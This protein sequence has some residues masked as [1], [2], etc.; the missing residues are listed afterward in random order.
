MAVGSRRRDAVALIGVLVLVGGLVWIVEKIRTSVNPVNSAT[1]YGAYLAVATLVV[2]L[3]AYLLP[4]WWKG[5]R[6]I[7]VSTAVQLTAA[8]DQL[9]QRILN[10]WRQEAKERLIST[11][12][13]VRVRWQWGPAQVTPSLMDVSTAPVAGTGPDSLPKPNPGGSC[14]NSPGVLLEAGVVTRLH[15]ELYRTLSHGR[16]VLLGEPG[17]GKTGAMI[18]LLLAA[19]EYRRSVDKAQRGQVPVPVLLTLGS[20]DP[21][22]QMLH[23]WAAATMYRDHPYLRALDYGPNAAEEL[24]RAGQVALFLDGLDEMAPSARGKALTRIEQE[25]AGLRIVLSSRPEEYVQAISTERI[26]NTAVI[27]VQPVDPQEAR[28]YLLRDQVGFQRDRWVQLGDYLTDHPGSVAAHALNTPLTLSLIRATYQNHDPTSLTDPAKFV[29]AAALRE[30]L[31]DRILVVVYPEECQRAHASRWLAWI[32]SQLG[33]E[34]D[35]AWWRISSWVP[36]WQLRLV[37]TI[38]GM[39]VGGLTYGFVAASV[40]GLD[41]GLVIGLVG[42]LGGALVGGLA[43]G[44][45]FGRIIGLVLGLGGGLVVGLGSSLGGALGGALVGGLVGGLASETESEPRTIFPRW[46]RPRELSI[47]LVVGLVVGLILGVARGLTVGLGGGLGGGLWA[48]FLPALVALLALWAAPLPRAASTTPTASYRSDR[49]A[50]LGVGLGGGLTLGLGGGLTLGL[51]LGLGG[52]LW[53]GLV[54]GLA[55]GFMFAL[56]SGWMKVNLTELLL[57]TAGAGKLKFIQ[58]LG[59]AHHRHVLRQAGAVYQFRHAELQDHL[60][61]IHRSQTRPPT[62][63]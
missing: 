29:T 13:P 55:L 62:S 37:G 63:T 16:L 45:K 10:D 14:L 46:P 20:W 53:V 34:R 2:S 30:H 50:S 12:A 22:T 47:L 24:L 18:L 8:A 32:A 21:A 48:G 5:R 60:A 23:Q 41:G 27:E 28:A 57:A 6:A 17:A 43:G 19:L 3:L 49:R 35:L 9:T 1:V 58:V 38:A 25:G 15:E 39:L 7:A 31:I 44:P 11:P 54:G 42:G 40:G 52:G 33:S 4:W 59:D 56:S 26:Y 51:G 36:R 61:E